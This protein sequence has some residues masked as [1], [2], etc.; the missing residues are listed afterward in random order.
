[1]ELI[2]NFKVFK[3]DVSLNMRADIVRPTVS[4]ID[5]LYHR[6]QKVLLATYELLINPFNPYS[7]FKFL[8]PFVGG[9]RIVASQVEVTDDHI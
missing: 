9:A 4:I 7:I 1:M 8:F 5:Y 6:I 3:P 2:N